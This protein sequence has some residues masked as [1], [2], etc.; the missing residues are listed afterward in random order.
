MSILL[1]ALFVLREF[2]LLD[3]ELHYPIPMKPTA[4]IKLLIISLFFSSPVMGAEWD[5]ILNR[6]KQNGVD[7]V[8]ALNIGQ[9]K[10]Q[11]G[12]NVQWKEID[13]SSRPIFAGSRRSAYYVVKDKTVFKNKVLPKELME[14]QSQLDLHEAFGALGYQDQAYSLSTSLDLISNARNAEVSQYLVNVLGATVFTEE[15]LQRLRSSDSSV[16]PGEGGGGDIT[17]LFVKSAVLK[18]ILS[19]PHVNSTEVLRHFPFINFEPQYNPKEQYI[20]LKYEFRDGSKNGKLLEGVPVQP[21]TGHQEKLSIW[22][23]VLNWSKSKSKRDRLV[24]DVAQKVFELFPFKASPDTPTTTYQ[25]CRNQSVTYATPSSQSVNRI[26]FLRGLIIGG[27]EITNMFGPLSTKLTIT[28]PSFDET[29]RVRYQAPFYICRLEE[30][31]KLVASGDFNEIEPSSTGEPGEIL[32]PDSSFNDFGYVYRNEKL[33]ITKFGFFNIN[34]GPKVVAFNGRRQTYRMVKN[35]IK[36]AITCVR[37][38]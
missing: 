15:N 14:I 26:Q 27:C 34:E 3:L 16:G 38:Q 1:T 5:T 25:T 33:E 6:L 7:Q 17:A 13:E 35:R 28:D 9:L 21:R 29:F 24:K 12:Q 8:G 22:V 2:G 23:P 11:I 19:R 36:Y 18:Q 37:Q 32:I 31:G 10:N 30:N 4:T 20:S